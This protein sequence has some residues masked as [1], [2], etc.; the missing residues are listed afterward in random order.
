MMSEY[1]RT[2]APVQDYGILVYSD[3][4]V[5]TSEWFD[6]APY[7]P[8]HTNHMLVLRGSQSSNESIIL[9][10]QVSIEDSWL[11]SASCIFVQQVG[12]WAVF[13]TI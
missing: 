13:A 1:T 10:L 9:V 6:W 2:H 12:D 11:E 8:F 3:V 7:L 4:S 5:S